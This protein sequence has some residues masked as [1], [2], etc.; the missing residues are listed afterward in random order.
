MRARLEERRSGVA[1]R[2]WAFAPDVP[3]GFRCLYL[4]GPNLPRRP[5]A[6]RRP[7]LSRPG[8]S[9]STRTHS[10]AVLVLFMWIAPFRWKSRV[11]SPALFG[12]A[13]GRS[14]GRYGFPVVAVEILGFYRHERTVRYSPIVAFGACSTLMAIGRRPGIRMKVS[15][16][17]PVGLR[18]RFFGMRGSRSGLGRRRSKAV[19]VPFAR[20]GETQSPP[21]G[22]GTVRSANRWSQPSRPLRGMN[23]LAAGTWSV[24]TW[25][26]RRMPTMISGVATEPRPQPHTAR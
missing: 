21:S 9:G 20:L 19:Q 2:S 12:S 17:G 13:G 15:G 26:S 25:L 16:R 6:R 22:S 8:R 3:T 4:D 11:R 24:M 5:L 18:V 23:T 1:S 7:L 14:F 10:G